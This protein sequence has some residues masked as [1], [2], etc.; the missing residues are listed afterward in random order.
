M[1][2][3][4]NTESATDNSVPAQDA[5]AVQ[6][7]VYLVQTF[8]GLKVAP[9]DHGEKEAHYR[10]KDGETWP[11]WLTDD[12]TVIRKW[13][14]AHRHAKG[15]P[16]NFIVNGGD[17][18][19]ILDLDRKAGGDGIGQWEDLAGE[20]G[21]T[22]TAFEDP[23]FT[24]TS[25]SGGEHRYY[26]VEEPTG[27]AHSL[28]EH[29]DVRG[30]GG[31]VLCPGSVIRSGRYRPRSGTPQIA[32][33]PQWAQP[34]LRRKGT[35]KNADD[36]QPIGD[37]DHASSIAKARDWLEKREPAIAHEQNA[38][39][40]YGDEWTFETCCYLR[41]FGLTKATALD[42]LTEEGGWNDRCQPP[43]SFGPEA[44][45]GDDLEAKLDSAWRNGQN[46]PGSRTGD[47]SALFGDASPS[48]PASGSLDPENDIEAPGKPKPDLSH[49]ELH[50][51]MSLAK[52]GK[53]TR[54]VIQDMLPDHGIAALLAR[55]GTGKT[56]TLLDI[57]A[58][59]ARDQRWMG[60][61]I[62]PGYTVCYIAAEDD[63]GV[64]LMMRGWARN[65]EADFPED[66]FLAIPQFP[67][68]VDTEQVDAWIE[69]LQEHLGDRPTV[70]VIDTWQRLT[71]GHGQSEDDAMS[72]AAQNLERLGKALN[73]PILAAFHPPKSGDLTILGSGIIENVT[74]AI[75][76][77]TKEDVKGAELELE[78]SRIKGRPEIAWKQYNIKQVDLGEDD[79]HG[80]PM[81][82]A[83]IERAAGYEDN[84]TK[85]TAVRNR[86]NAIR[87]A[88]AWAPQIKRAMFGLE[89]PTDDGCESTAP[90]I[91]KRLIE[92]DAKVQY[93]EEGPGS[94]RMKQDLYF[95]KAELDDNGKAPQAAVKHLKRIFELGDWYAV[96]DTPNN[97]GKVFAIRWAREKGSKA[98]FQTGK[99]PAANV[100]RVIDDTRPDDDDDQ[101]TGPDQ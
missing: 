45:R 65:N 98:H 57:A 47:P 35:R 74:T 76:F 64:E 99:V 54:Y 71:A 17:R 93:L 34:Y 44:A 85:A 21:D 53:H 37:L 73:G 75:W 92:V 43:W 23:T 41:D 18:Y 27:N 12:P 9:V 32:P 62:I 14:R 91:A 84:Q 24:V 11:D 39:G 31:Y 96:D 26:A 82:A 83:V 79:E 58:A 78:V 40:K 67:S 4:K 52:R 61:S 1:I 90:E 88:N 25:P 15:K 68:L 86:H 3:R 49:V 16:C 100:A 81:T 77:L 22:T 101:I 19:V 80:D 33:L 28:P 95:Q 46:T 94:Q 70:L 51:G 89:R 13:D 8:P 38:A 63:G 97:N 55:R 87:K 66:R 56:L 50:W 2:I 72:I 5:D 10:A 20:H 59:I 69:L 36:A 42:L 6:W 29:I 7:A 60:Q 48:A 30:K